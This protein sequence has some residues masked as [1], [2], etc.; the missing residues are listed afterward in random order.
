VSLIWLWRTLYCGI[1]G[2]SQETMEAA[3][4]SQNGLRG[5]EE[6]AGAS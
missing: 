1:G 5:G 3:V 6:V 4:P 2:V